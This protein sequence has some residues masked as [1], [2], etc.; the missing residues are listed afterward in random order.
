MLTHFESTA[1]HAFVANT[2]ENRNAYFTLLFQVDP[3]SV[4]VD[5]LKGVGSSFAN[6]NDNPNSSS[7]PSLEFQYASNSTLSSFG[8]ADHV[9]SDGSRGSRGSRLHP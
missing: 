4:N 3:S 9:S 1:R 6:L 2:L 7:V 5:S 8:S